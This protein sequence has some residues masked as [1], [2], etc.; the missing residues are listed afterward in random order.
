MEEMKETAQTTETSAPVEKAEANEAQIADSANEG[1]QDVATEQQSGENV[2]PTKPAQT[3]EENS[4]FARQR[5]EKEQQAKIDKA[6]EEARIQAII[7][8]VGSNPYTNEPLENEFDVKIYQAMKQ[9]EKEG[10][11][12]IA[13]QAKIIKSI[14]NKDNKSRQD[15]IQQE[16]AKTESENKAKSELD[17]LV[18]AY[19][20]VN[21][22]ELL[23]DEDFKDYA[24]GKVGTK[25]LK[26]LYEGFV[27]LTGKRAVAQQEIEEKARQQANNKASVGSLA[28]EA[29]QATGIPTFEQVQNASRDQIR[30]WR[31]SGILAKAMASW[32]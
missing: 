18:K 26:Q 22:A 17:E 14:V 6:K 7:D 10:G 9:Y 25:P 27:K 30:A 28:G 4:E 20:D 23:N 31:E 32:K 8:V 21:V 13:D 3:K 1:N 15:A 12:P 24:E 16:I 2:E 11:D 29:S 5:R 19:P